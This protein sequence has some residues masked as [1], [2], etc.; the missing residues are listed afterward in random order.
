[1]EDGRDSGWTRV[2]WQEAVS[3][4]QRSGHRHTDIQQRDV[5]RSRNRED[6]R[7]HQHEADFIEQS[8][9]DGKTG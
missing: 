9:T 6:Q 3:H 2:R 7:Q 4:G 1:M 5:R 8:E